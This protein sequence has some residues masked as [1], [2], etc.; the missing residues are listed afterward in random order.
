MKLPKLIEGKNWEGYDSEEI[1]AFLGPNFSLDFWR[2][3]RGKTGVS[4]FV[5]GK[6]GFRYIVYKDDFKKFCEN[7][8]ISIGGK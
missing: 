1:E 7:V 4:D 8:G 6:D 3:F 5:I 2:W